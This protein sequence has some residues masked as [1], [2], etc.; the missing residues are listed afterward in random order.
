M[1]LDEKPRM[2]GV[3]ADLL[4]RVGGAARWLRSPQVF[5]RDGSGGPAGFVDWFEPESSVGK[6]YLYPEITG[7]AVSTLEWLIRVGE[8]TGW[9]P[10]ASHE[11]IKYL[12]ERACDSRGAVVGC[13]RGIAARCR[14]TFDTGMVLKGLCAY[15]QRT[16]DPC[17]L[18]TMHR[19]AGY[20]KSQVSK[21]GRIAP[22]QPLSGS[23]VPKDSWSSRPGAYLSKTVLALTCF[24][25]LTGAADAVHRLEAVVERT[26]RDQDAAGFFPLPGRSVVHLHC[27]LYACEALFLLGSLYE[28]D[29]LCAGARLGTEAAL[30][31]FERYGRLPASLGPGLPIDVERS[32][33]VAQLLRLCV[34]T[35]VGTAAQHASLANR[36]ARY[37]VETAAGY[38]GLRFGDDVDP[39]TGHVVTCRRHINTWSTLFALQAWAGLAV[40]A[41][42]DLWVE[43]PWLFA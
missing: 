30:A 17:V 41:W 40:P 23:D 3:A 26:L 27:H 24:T 9:E 34:L 15:Y 1:K 29:Q 22:C 37:Q 5:R 33:G 32:D 18:E 8:A 36:L 19:C 21:D 7:Y 10:A 39:D 28:A 16:R 35:G 31:A 20:I 6:G 25:R 11:A 2:P 38:G 42:A 14:Y 43:E 12:T 4:K 13:G